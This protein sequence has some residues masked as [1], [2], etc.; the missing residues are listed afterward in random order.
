MEIYVY[1]NGLLYLEEETR[2]L[3]IKEREMGLTR[4]LP[5]KDRGMTSSIK[6]EELDLDPESSSTVE[7]YRFR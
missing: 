2:K 4:A 6:V 1:T 3:M 7:G 5:L